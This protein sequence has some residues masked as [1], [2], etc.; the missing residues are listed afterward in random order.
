LF[1][2]PLWASLAG[3]TIFALA[4]HQGILYLVGL[5]CY[6]LAVVMLLEPFWAPLEVGLLMSFNLAVQ[7]VVLRRVGREDGHNRGPNPL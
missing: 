4:S 5:L 1:V 2:Y 6:V 3:S 7:G